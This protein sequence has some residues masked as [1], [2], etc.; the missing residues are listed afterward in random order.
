MWLLALETATPMLSVALLKNGEPVV[1]YNERSKRRHAQTV[2]PTIADLL[3]GQGLRPEDVGAVA[4]GSG[5][6][7][8]TGLRIG[9]STAKGLAQAL[10]IPLITV[11]TL[12]ILAAA[13]I[14]P[15]TVTA[16]LL[17]AKQGHIYVAFYRNSSPA[18]L[19]APAP[20]TEYL[21]LKPPQVAAEAV[22]LT[23]DKCLTVCGDGVALCREELIAAGLKVVELPSW[24]SM[25]RASILGRLA[26]QRLAA[27]E[28]Q[29]VATAQPLY[30][31]R[32]AAE[33][34]REAKRNDC[35]F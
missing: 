3:Q 17:D 16:P 14:R 6:G 8:F 5:P 20:L 22:R 31:R 32:A 18:P 27:G 7:S 4:C 1:E 21:A 11:S 10:N 9:L 2:A 13:A 26:A 35:T 25:P 33:L 12:D 19:L 34:A 15:D 30:V 23:A 28:S 29:N 24:Y